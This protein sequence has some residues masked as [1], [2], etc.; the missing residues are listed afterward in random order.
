MDHEHGLP[1]NPEFD[2]LDAEFEVMC[3]KCSFQWIAVC[4][5][6]MNVFHCEK[7][8]AFAGWKVGH[9]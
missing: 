2:P 8:G 5:E 9:C 3:I 6:G 4:Y 1:P 7:C